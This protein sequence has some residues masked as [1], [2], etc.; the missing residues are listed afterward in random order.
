MVRAAMK[1][2]LFSGIVRMLCRTGS[3]ESKVLGALSAAGML[4]VFLLYAGTAWAGSGAVDLPRFPSIS[5]DGSRIVF[6][7]GGDLWLAGIQG[8][9]K[10]DV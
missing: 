3:G 8:G 7:S 4:L 10:P 5:P 6:S 1:D 2:C 9:E